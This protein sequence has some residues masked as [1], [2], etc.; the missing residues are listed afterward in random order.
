MHSSKPCMAYL[1]WIISVGIIAFDQIS[2]AYVSHSLFLGES[3]PI[4]RNMF[5]LSLVYNTGVAFGLFKNYGL[6]FVA[7]SLF[8][9]GYIVRDSISNQKY[10]SRRKQIAFSLI[11]GGACGNVIDRLHFGYIVDFLDFR[12]WPVFNIADS[13]I[14]IGIALLA[15]SLLKKPVTRN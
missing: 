5:H 12:I 8:V 3:I 4:I 14:T 13:A 11:L 7:I 1:P 9:I 6:V 2:K 10:Y 15:Y